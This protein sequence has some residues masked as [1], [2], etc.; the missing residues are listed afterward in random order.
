MRPGFRKNLMEYGGIVKK[1]IESPN[2]QENDQLTRQLYD[3]AEKKLPK[4]KPRF[5]LK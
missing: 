2:R 3:L 5:Q 1:Q 4:D